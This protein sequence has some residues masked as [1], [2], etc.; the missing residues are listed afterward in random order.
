MCKP[1]KGRLTLWCLFWSPSV[2]HGAMA[3]VGEHC[4]RSEKGFTQFFFFFAI[5][6]CMLG[7]FILL[8]FILLITTCE[9]NN[10]MRETASAKVT[11]QQTVGQ[12]KGSIC[13]IQLVR[14]QEET[15]LATYKT[16]SVEAIHGRKWLCMPLFSSSSFTGWVGRAVVLMQANLPLPSSLRNHNPR[17]C[18][19]LCVNKTI[20]S[21]ETARS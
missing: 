4:V 10:I 2:Q 13:E 18:S 21:S 16:Q 8:S 1:V 5:L 19:Q 3:S 20:N 11:V 6:K 15:N 12:V 14:L 7:L 9:L 17:C